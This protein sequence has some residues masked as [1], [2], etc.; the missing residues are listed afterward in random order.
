MNKKIMLSVLATSVLATPSAFAGAV[1]NLTGTDG[2]SAEPYVKGTNIV[3]VRLDSG[4]TNLSGVNSL[5]APSLNFTTA[6][7][8]GLDL[9]IGGGLN[10]SNI[11]SSLSSLSSGAVFPWVRA[12]IPT[13]I[14]NVKTGIM[15]GTSIPVNPNNSINGGNNAMLNMMSRE[16]FPGATALADIYLG[17]ALGSSV[18]LTMGLNAGY[19]RGLTSGTNLVSGNIN[20]TLPTSNFIAYE[21]QFINYPVGGYSN[22][23]F[24]LGFSVPVADKWMIDIKPAAL[25]EANTTGTTWSF[26][27]SVG[28]SVKF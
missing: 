24:R 10:F 6:V 20:F 28:A 27:P 17:Q 9:G 26:N 18:P 14:D 21:E 7:A 13:N 2:F 5:L 1:N 23:G 25:W 12:A 4:F 22:G 16:F 11:G 19:A 15:I 8:D 3:H